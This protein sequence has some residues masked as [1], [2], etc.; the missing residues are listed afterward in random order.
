MTEV[1]EPPVGTIALLFT[2]VEGSTRLAARLG[3]VWPDVLAKHH[4]L[5]SA[6]IADED[7][8]VEGT[9]GDAFFATFA[10]PAAA[11]R[12]AVWV[13]CGSG[14][15]CTLATWSEPRLVMWDWKF[16]VRRGS[17]RR[18]MVGSCC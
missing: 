15:D 12:A 9:E 4:A 10:D 3:R 18:L 1:M 5:V 13:S 17:R 11:A 14:W 6:A 7:G 2:D 16:T 8:Y